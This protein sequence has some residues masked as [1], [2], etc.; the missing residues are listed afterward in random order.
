MSALLIHEDKRMAIAHLIAEASAC[1]DWLRNPDASA[2]AR[3]EAQMEAPLHVNRLETLVH[4]LA[5]DRV[6]EIYAP[7]GGE[8]FLERLRR[9]M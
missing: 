5:G 8:D 4:A 6:H 9:V 7:D 2:E 3:F 1:L